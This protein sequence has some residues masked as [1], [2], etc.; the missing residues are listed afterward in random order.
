MTYRHL[1]LACPVCGY[2]ADS[3][4]YAGVPRQN[5]HKPPADEDRSVC[6][7]CASINIFALGG[8]ALRLPTADER[9]ETARNPQVQRLVQVLI[10]AKDR[11]DSWPRA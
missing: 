4:S 8:T 7:A 5:D 11:S 10:T 6:I 1:E 2:K 9:A 3:A